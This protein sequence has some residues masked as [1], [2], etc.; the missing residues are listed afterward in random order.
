VR[1]L[2]LAL[3]NEATVAWVERE[4]H[5]HVHRE[6]G[7]APLERYLDGKSVGR[8]SPTP[9]EL[10]AAFTQEAHRIQRRSDGT[11]TVE[12]VRFELPGRMR[13]V[14]RVVVRYASWDLGHVLLC[15][16]RT[17]VV[18]ERLW[19]LDKA[20]NADGHRRA[21]EPTAPEPSLAPPP[22]GLAPLLDKLITDYRA[23]GLPPA[24]LPK[25]EETD[26]E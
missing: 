23:D 16:E 19:P 12:G 2:S 5:R 6:I 9:A 18:I 24:S 17:G 25:N 8:P 26:H 3:L 4:Y 20:K 1:D 11:I 7:V 21:L 22:A 13:H 15:D 10:R 14:D